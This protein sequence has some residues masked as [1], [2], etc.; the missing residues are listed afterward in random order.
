[1]LDKEHPEIICANEFNYGKGAALFYTNSTQLPV[2]YTDDIFE[3]LMLQN[4]LQ[5]E[6]TGGTVLHI[7]LGE[8]KTSRWDLYR[9]FL[10]TKNGVQLKYTSIPSGLLNVMQLEFMKKQTSIFLTQILTQIKKRVNHNLLTP[11]FYWCPRQE[12]DL[13]HMD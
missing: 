13:R 3:T 6:Y 5:T 10:A 12:S 11:C 2:N 1:M 9:K 4:D 7:Y 8:H